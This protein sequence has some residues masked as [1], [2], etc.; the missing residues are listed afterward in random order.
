L[1]SCSHIDSK[2]EFIIA[3]AHVVVVA[4]GS[5]LLQLVSCINLWC[6]WIHSAVVDHCMKL[7]VVAVLPNM[8]L[9]SCPNQ[10]T[11]SQSADDDRG[12]YMLMMTVCS[13]DQLRA[14]ATWMLH[15]VFSQPS[16]PRLG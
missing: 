6:H 10:G 3:Q 12:M 8:L 9:A 4:P 5:T 15:G 1:L 11:Q 16:I 13:V 2:Y 14:K 7:R